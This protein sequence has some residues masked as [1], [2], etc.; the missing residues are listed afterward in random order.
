[1]QLWKDWELQLLVLLSFMLQVFVLFSGGLR[2]CSTNSALRLLIWLAYLLS[3]LVAVY[4]LGQLSQHESDA[5]GVGE[6]HKLKFFWTPFLLIHLGGQDTITAFSIEDN[7]LW[8]RHLLNLLTQVGLAI[9]VFWKS[10]IQNQLFIPAILI[11]VAGIIKYGERTWALKCAS[12]KALR[13][14]CD[15]EQAGQFPELDGE[16]KLDYLT[17]V[18][19]ALSSELGVTN[20]FVGRKIAKMKGSIQKIFTAAN[21][22]QV[23]AK[24]RLIFKLLEIELGMMYDNLYT[25]T[26]V[27]RTWLGAVIRCISH[28]SLVIAFVL[29]VLG[30][31]NQR[32]DSKVDVS[33]TYA[34]FVGAFCTEISAVFLVVMMSPF[35]WALLEC[36]KCQRLARVAW[37]IFKNLQPE[38]RPRWSDSMGQFNFLNSCFSESMIGKLMN[39][40]GAKE[41]WRNFRHTKNVQIKPELKDAI[42]ETKHHPGML[43]GGTSPSPGLGPALDTIL[44]KP[45]EEAILFLHVYTDIF[46]HRY[47]NPANA[48]SCHI[49]DKTRHLMDTCRR[50]S[51]YMVYLLVLNPSM[52]SVSSDTRDI[53]E[54]ASESVA[55]AR[56]TDDLS[57]EQFLEKLATDQ[58]LYA[59]SS[60]VLLA[61]FVFQGESPSH[62]SLEFLAY[63]WA[64]ILLYAAGKS[65]GEVHAKQLSMGGEFITFVWLYMAHCTLGDMGFVELEL[66]RSTGINDYGRSGRKAFIWDNQ[67]PP[68]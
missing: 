6:K 63:A 44:Q 24:G 43:Q 42:F 35:P 46:L 57:K 12:Q 4:T 41:M 37:C 45:F 62:E 7:E 27:V 52:L 15:V 19:Y 25:K 68:P 59:P 66:V 26:R 31:N 53:L 67:P 54:E 17:I 18:K 65:R 9:Y 49:S 33:I 3:D 10:P 23:P 21:V 58:Y 13:D 60:P 61:G 38:S 56:A 30:N 55:K 29:F 1:M 50:I 16:L 51:E 20:L 2:R 48:A 64:M 5:D 36:W 40:V 32:Y 8:L 11:F 28:I 47:K 14:S 34:L 22:F 39:L